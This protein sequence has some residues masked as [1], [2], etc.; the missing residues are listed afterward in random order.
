MTC[1]SMRDGPLHCPTFQESFSATLALL[2]RGRAW[3]AND[4]GG[5]AAR[6]LAW[7]AALVGIP[8]TWPFGYVQVAVFA[9]FA[10]VRNFLETRLCA[11]RLEFWCATH[12]ETDDLWM[13]EYGLPDSCD[14]FPDLCTKVSAIGGAR[15]EYF[16]A[17]VARIGWTVDCLDQLTR[18]GARCGCSRAG[19]AQAGLRRGTGLVLRVHTGQS[20]AV[21]RGSFRQIIPRAGT[22][23]AGQRPICDS[24]AVPSIVPIRCLMD[25]I[26][27]AHMVIEYVT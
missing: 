25:R 7:L 2:P 18:C 8:V 20:P 9:A 10:S 17:I 11:L 22:M 19:T 6:Y 1:A 13:A 4:G 14:P 24:V 12:V 26:A 3:P 5:I 15:C 27:P 21:V 23:R 16:N